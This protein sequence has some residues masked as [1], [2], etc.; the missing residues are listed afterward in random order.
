[1]AQSGDAAAEFAE[2]FAWLRADTLSVLL[3]AVGLL[4]WL[5]T[6]PYVLRPEAFWPGWGTF[7]ALGI[8]VGLCYW[9]GT[10][11][12][13]L[14]S[15]LFIGGLLL[16]AAVFV[17]APGGSAIA[18]FMFVPVVLIA[19]VLRGSR[20]AFLAAGAATLAIVAA[21]LAGATAFAP[22]SAVGALALIWLTAL[23]S[24]A[25]TRNLYVALHWALTN[26]DQ[27]ERNLA[28]ARQYQGQV[29]AANRQLEEAN[30]R[31]E[32][33]N[34]AL[35]WARAEAEQARQQKAQFAANISHELRTPINLV[36]GFAELMLGH[37]EKYGL[38]LPNEYQ[39]DLTTVHRNAQHLRGLIDDILDL[40][41]IEAGE[42]PVLLET[43]D[44]RAVVDEALAIA[45]QLLERKGLAISL[46]LAPDL[47][48]LRVDRL[49][50]RQVLLNLLSN[51]SRFTERG[52]VVVRAR[53]DREHVVVEVADTGL[54]IPPGRIEELFQPFHQ[55]ETSGTRG[56][57]GSGLGLAISRRFVELHGG[58]IWA[59]SSGVPGEGST[60]AFALP[61]HTADAPERRPAGEPARGGHA[62]PPPTAV[63]MDDDPAIVSLFQRRLDG[64]HV[65]GAGS[66]AEA[67][68]LAADRNAHVVLAD[69]P[70]DDELA[71]W[72][73]GWRE[74]AGGASVR[75]V[76]CP[77]PSG[78]RIARTLGLVDYL[79][80]PVARETLLASVRAVAPAARTVLVTDDDPQMVRLLCGM[81]GTTPERY[82][83]L[84]AYDGEQALA[85]MREAHPD[86]VL[87]DLLMP[88]AGGLAVLEQMK[89]EPALAAIPVVA[90][91]AH[92]AF[93]AI[94]ASGGRALVVL[95]TEPPPVGRMVRLV[96]AVLDALP[97]AEAA[98]GPALERFE[99]GRQR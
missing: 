25:T 75:V 26:S 94:S 72:C 31:L 44:L 2:S 8:L 10:A 43:T 60:F 91:S 66:A 23:T 27:A 48:S 63:V 61:I 21:G 90:I 97:P 51:A 3:R 93:E 34:H 99:Q 39:I 9:L 98:G 41:Q 36:V 47:P 18:L 1:M 55:L 77:M 84:R 53:R 54:G 92:G 52:G 50:I 16:G 35:A 69:L 20:A 37:P 86:L 19:G 88:R 71:R 12:F 32:R 49:R 79:V 30:Y 76:G 5:G 38:P 70:G 28:E 22:A 56:R 42:M 87:I 29:A 83:L 57:G 13:A 7:V 78:R 46:D 96:Q 45:G 14:T 65:V 11:R 59:T 74:A 95:E 6:V 67:V 64:Y 85:Q 80:K 58:A 17:M 68:S 40:S 24:W 82:R 4:V 73:L 81:L 15:R 89:R 62:A 33:A